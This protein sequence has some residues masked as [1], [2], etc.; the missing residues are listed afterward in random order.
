[1]S[2]YES[3]LSDLRA[4]GKGGL[5]LPQL[6]ID[7]GLP[8]RKLIA[9]SADVASHTFKASLRLDPDA[10]GSTL[11]D[12]TVTVYPFSG[13]FTNLLLSLTDGQTAALPGDAA[14]EG[15]VDLAFDILITPP[16]DAQQRLL[17]GVI[18]VLGKVT[19]YG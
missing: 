18:P 17:G 10:T 15:S 9:I 16:A 5:R 3:W 8:Y 7:R 14:A 1:M 19:N 11:V 12:F 13:G 2:N 6:A 4:A